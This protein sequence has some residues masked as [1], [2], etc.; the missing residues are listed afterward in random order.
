MEETVS[1]RW[2]STLLSD[3]LLHPETHAQILTLD[4]AHGAGLQR[5]AV[6]PRTKQHKKSGSRKRLHQVNYKRK[7][8]GLP[9]SLFPLS[10]T[11]SQFQLWTSHTVRPRQDLTTG[12]ILCSLSFL[13]LF[14][15]SLTLSGQSMAIIFY[16]I[17]HTEVCC[18]SGELSK[19]YGL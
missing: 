2:G 16:S 14:L 9:C 18:G 10:F 13:L 11:V 19:C 15:F 12:D 3:S 8:I 7:R 6:D 5:L 17:L 1:L 4:S